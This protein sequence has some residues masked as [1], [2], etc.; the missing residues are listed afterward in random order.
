MARFHLARCHS[1]K[2]SQFVVDFHYFS[3]FFTISSAR[4]SNSSR[5]AA[6]PAWGPQPARW[7]DIVVTGNLGAAS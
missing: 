6:I 4:S 5:P 7:V 2:S 1:F 3:V